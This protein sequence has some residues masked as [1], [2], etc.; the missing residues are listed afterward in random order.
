MEVGG[1][2]STIMMH[3]RKNT[4]PTWN[5]CV[6]SCSCGQCENISLSALAH[7]SGSKGWRI[8]LKWKLE[9]N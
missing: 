4:V 1:G 7:W 3:G 6:L 2:V 5:S 8:F 9:S